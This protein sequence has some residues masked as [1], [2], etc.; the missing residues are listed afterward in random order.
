[1]ENVINACLEGREGN[2]ILPFLW[3]HG[4]DE[5]VLRS[6]MAAIASANIRAVCVE[7]R[8]HPDFL[9]EKW[10]RD[11]DVIL[12]EARKRDMKVWILDDKHYPTGSAAGAIAKAPAEL[13]KQFLAC[14]MTDVCG[15]QRRVRL[16]LNKLGKTPQ[17]PFNPQPPKFDDDRLLA[18]VA[19]RLDGAIDRN[20][21]HMEEVILL[22]WVQ[23]EDFFT[24][25]VPAGM[26][27]VF[28]FYITHNGGDDRINLADRASCKVLLDTVYEPH[29]ARYAADFGK[30]IA[31]FFSDEPGLGNPASPSQGCIVGQTRMPL[32]W[33]RELERNLE[34][35]WGKDYVC[36]LPALWGELGTREDTAAIREG[37]MNTVTGLVESCFSQQL[38][39][40]C[41]A[42][43][44]EYIGHIIEDNNASEGLSAST[45]HFFRSLWGQDMAG[46][47]DIG[48]QLTVGG[49][50]TEHSSVVGSGDGEF[51]HHV[52]GK[53]GSSLAHIDPKKKDRCVCECFGAYGWTE[54]TQTMKYIADHL[55][56]DGVNHFVPHAF[57]AKA[58]PDFDC[59]PHFYAGGEDILFPAFGKL[60]AYMNR[61]AHVLSTCRHSAP[62][63]I[64]YHAESA[65][66]GRPWMKMQKCAR[67]LRENQIDFDILPSECLGLKQGKLVVNGRSYEALVVPGCEYLTD[68]ALQFCQAAE[69]AGFPVYFGDFKPEG[70]AGKVVSLQSLPGLLADAAHVKLTSAHDGIRV[71]HGIHGSSHVYFLFN[72]SPWEGFAGEVRV[73]ASGNCCRYDP[74]E[75]RLYCRDMTG[76]KIAVNLPPM[77]SALFVV[78]QANIPGEPE[79]PMPQHSAQ[80]DG[81]WQV[82]LEENGVFAPW[83]G[84]NPLDGI[85]KDGWSG[86]ARYT[87]TVPAGLIPDNP[88]CVV[89]HLPQV[90]ETARVWCNGIPVGEAIAAPFRFDLTSCWS[91]GENKLQIDVTTTMEQKVKAASGGRDWFVFIQKAWFGYGLTDTPVIEYS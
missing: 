43:G 25:D 38:G 40:W 30:T 55:L 69:T 65:W 48:S 79:L 1:M 82:F 58:F 14:N 71:Y 80:L 85:W 84:E 74:M 31:G 68:A 86:T 6:Y 3:L 61:T 32:P 50:N 21:S 57:S 13:H 18:L 5:A 52:L 47:D 56:A 73:R 36:K 12:D 41:R 64:L 28:A 2:F 83:E 26:W 33:S 15:P 10:W 46:I 62:V 35:L 24:W 75:N 11:L 16:D 7:S 17:N 70:A 23:G 51:Y 63:A 8:P 76:S 89:L 77:E 60:M 29:Y 19:A 54:G 27:R 45:G 20:L 9:R 78:T 90:R 59:P 72:S 88:G 22:P 81:Q 37:Y 87:Y 91:A 42:H 39:D 4:E 53:L 67:V 34:A 49:A 44:V 66:S